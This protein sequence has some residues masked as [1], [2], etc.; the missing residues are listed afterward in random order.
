MATAKSGVVGRVALR[1]SLLGFSKRALTQKKA[2]TVEAALTAGVI[3]KNVGQNTIAQTPSS[4]SPG[5]VGRIWT[6][7]MFN[8]FDAT[9]TQ[10]GNRI[11]VKYGW[12]KR[13]QKYY[14]TQEYGGFF[15][16]K[17]ITPMHAMA[18]ATVAAQDYLNSK[19][20]K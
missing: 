17:T 9:V 5:K 20:I 14:K 7:A 8:D 13:K 3:A 2:D 19:G 15:I 16:G 10:T 6:G 12:I 18:N 11:T 4:L 1:N